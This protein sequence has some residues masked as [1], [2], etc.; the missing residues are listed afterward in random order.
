MILSHSKQ[1]YDYSGL[2]SHMGSSWW[3]ERKRTAGKLSEIDGRQPHK[4]AARHTAAADKQQHDAHGAEGAKREVVTSRLLVPNSIALQMF[5]KEISWVWPCVWQTELE[6]IED[7]WQSYYII[8]KALRRLAKS[9]L[10]KRR[11]CRGWGSSVG[12]PAVHD[13]RDPL[14]N[15]NRLLLSLFLLLV[16]PFL[17]IIQTKFAYYY[18]CCWDNT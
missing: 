5:A 7:L 2:P 16:C 3:G 17:S 8:Q 18:C 14:C 11:A 1:S 15:P 9:V 12:S 6:M 4:Q 10:P 13:K